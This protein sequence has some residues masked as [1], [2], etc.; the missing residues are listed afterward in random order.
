MN[1]FFIRIIILVHN[2]CTCITLV[3]NT[4]TETERLKCLVFDRNLSPLT[5]YELLNILCQI[6]ALSDNKGV[7]FVFVW[8]GTKPDFAII[9]EKEWLNFKSV[10]NY[11][12]KSPIELILLPTSHVSF[13]R[14]AHATPSMRFAY[15]SD[16]KLNLMKKERKKDSA[17]LFINLTNHLGLPIDNQQPF[18]YGRI[19]DFDGCID[20]AIVNVSISDNLGGSLLIHAGSA[21]FATVM[22]CFLPKPTINY[23]SILRLINKS[24]FIRKCLLFL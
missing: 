9:Q 22:M 1:F 15:A 11:F 23:F 18:I 4:C 8:D 19:E 14:R 13:D 24:D 16:Q 5:N 6:F 3:D 20:G 17:Y 2:K 10:P 12:I 7:K 21:I